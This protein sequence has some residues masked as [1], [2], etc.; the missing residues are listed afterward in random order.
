MNFVD[1]ELERLS[2][3]VAVYQTAR[4][5]YGKALKDLLGDTA[6]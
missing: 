6:H 3:Q 5:A 2:A 1:A 4:V